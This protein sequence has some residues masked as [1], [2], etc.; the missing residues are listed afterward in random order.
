M[1]D[2]SELLAKLILEESISAIAVLSERTG[3]KTDEVVEMIAELKSKGRLN[4]SLTED[5]SRFFKSTVK[6]SDARVIPREEKLPEFLSYNTKPGKVTAIVGL[7]ILV[8]GAV[9]TVL[10][11]DIEEQN[12][13]AVLILIGLLVFLLGLYLIAR[14][15]SPS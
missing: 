6:V 8:S 9:I 15:G 2:K 3:L 14:R 4:G 7:L 13:A 1:K 10:A 12:F 5:G 11:S